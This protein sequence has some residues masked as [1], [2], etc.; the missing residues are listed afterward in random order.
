VKEKK[1]VPVGERAVMERVNRRLAEVSQLL[2]ICRK[3]PWLEELGRYFI[4]S[5]ETGSLVE[6][7]VNLRECAEGLGA[8]QSWE[9]ITYE[10]EGET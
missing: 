10:K 1:R 3:G 8:L 4:V 6:R 7:H 5:T 2:K 9:K